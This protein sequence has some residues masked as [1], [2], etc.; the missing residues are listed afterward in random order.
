MKERRV[1]LIIFYN[2]DGKIL[3]Q[4]REGISKYGEEWGYF[5]GQIENGETPEQAVI[6]E[7]KEELDFNLKEYKFIDEVT[8][9]DER[10][11]I[12]RE[13]FISK[14]PP[15]NEIKQI[16]G[17]NMK[18]FTLDEAKEKKKVFGDDKV[19]QKLKEIGWSPD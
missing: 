15:M 12:I 5:G 10:G 18:L 16:E 3:L 19:I 17:K 8:T 2:K 6:R 14:L 4:D 9:I 13:V 1:A 11:K 7:T